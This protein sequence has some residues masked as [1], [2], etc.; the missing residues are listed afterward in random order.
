M[1]NG[2][3]WVYEADRDG[4]KVMVNGD[5]VGL[6]TQ[7]EGGWTYWRLLQK[8]LRSWQA[9]TSATSRNKAVELGLQ[10]DDA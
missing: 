8:P 1:S 3:S 6:V 7:E 5:E 2:V 9:V 10:K 4:Y